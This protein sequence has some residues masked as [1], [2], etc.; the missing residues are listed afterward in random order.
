M[1]LGID[2][3]TQVVV[4]LT[5]LSMGNT[6]KMCGEMYGLAE[7]TTSIIIRECCKTIKVLVKS[8][9]FPKLI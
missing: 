5:R 8:L 6:L 9:V 1:D 3:E 7:S 2:I 4:I